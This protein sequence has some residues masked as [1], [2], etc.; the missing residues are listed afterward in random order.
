MLKIK[1]MLLGLLTTV[2]LVG[3]NQP[4]EKANQEVDVSAKEVVKDTKQENLTPLQ[5][6]LN[7]QT[8]LDEAREIDIQQKS[9]SER[10]QNVEVTLT[11]SGL[12]D[13]SINAERKVYQFKKVQDQWQQQGESVNTQRCGRGDDTTSFH[14][15]VCP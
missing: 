15:K 10:A 7:Q 4:T 5:Q 6:V 13:D 2:A 9:D 1:I 11:L 14:S 12:A 8:Y 3:C